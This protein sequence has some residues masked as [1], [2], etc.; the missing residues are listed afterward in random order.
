MNLNP[1]V[2]LDPVPLDAEQCVPAD[3]RDID[4]TCDHR[5]LHHLY[6]H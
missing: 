2:S 5:T 1:P 4:H 3:H 6:R